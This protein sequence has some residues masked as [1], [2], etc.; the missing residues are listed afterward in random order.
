MRDVMLD[1]WGRRSVLKELL[2]MSAALLL[3]A[4]RLC[5]RSLFGPAS[6]EYQIEISS[7][8]QRTLRLSVLPVSDGKTSPIPV[9]GSLVQPTW[10]APAATLSDDWHAQT[11]KAGDLSVH[12]TPA[13]LT[14]AIE[15]SAGKRVQQL[16]VDRQTGAVLFDTGNSPLF[17]LGE[18]GPQFDRRGSVD[19][20]VGG[21]G[22]YKLQTHGG[23]VPI[24]WIISTSG[25]AMFFHQPYGTFDFSAVQS[26]F[27][28]VAA[29]RALP[30]DLFF[31]AS[32]DPS[33]IMGEY[34][35]LTGHP[36]MPP[37]WSFGYQQSH[38]TLASREEV[39]QE[40]ETFRQKNLPCDALIYLGTGF[41][42][43]GWNTENGSFVWN[44]HVFPN[45]KEV[46]DRLHQNNFRAV[47]H[48]VIL[49]DRLH[50]SVHDSCELAKFD[51]ESA[52]CYWDAHRRD[53]ALG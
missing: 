24:P 14:F 48:A 38:R 13:P 3:P 8:S 4:K 37:L 5:A 36:E 11:V 42:P 7:V 52:S 50:G 18:G 43:S 30:L 41:C 22:G 35:R 31:V 49:S 46:L 47:L 2:A 9:D 34:A 19:R 17:G 27:E 28:P 45:P 40:A 23:R 6:P 33:V 25:W 15:T 53:F 21:Q 20:M 1:R 29:G 12:I 51:E 16:T 10:G 32:A 44:Y 39:V 26:K